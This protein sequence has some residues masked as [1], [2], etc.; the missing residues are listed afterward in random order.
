MDKDTT[1]CKM[2]FNFHQKLSK[3]SKF[4][5]KKNDYDVKLTLA[6]FNEYTVYGTFHIFTHI[7]SLSEINKACNNTSIIIIFT[8]KKTH[9]PYHFLLNLHDASL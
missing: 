2:K 3:W 8:Y 6:E 9:F 1:R 7:I 5:F 4:I